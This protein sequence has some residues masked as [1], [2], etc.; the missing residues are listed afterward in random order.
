MKKNNKKWEIHEQIK[1]CFPKVNSV[2]PRVFL[3]IPEYEATVYLCE[4]EE[5]SP[6]LGALSVNFLEFKVSR[7]A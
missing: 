6:W 7:L 1:I 4:T 2:V 5:P 3:G